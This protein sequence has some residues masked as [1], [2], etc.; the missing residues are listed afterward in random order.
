MEDCFAYKRNGCIALKV[1]KCEGC[2][3][4]KTKEQHQLDQQKALDR[5]RAL[6]TDRRDYII[7]TY[8]GGKLEVL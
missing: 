1:I 3:F 7:K 2:S 4:Y 6:D 5:I 8:Y